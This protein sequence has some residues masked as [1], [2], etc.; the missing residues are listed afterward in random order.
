M[1]TVRILLI[2]AAVG[3]LAG[4]GGVVGVSS[5][6][7]TTV[8]A[9]GSVPRASLPTADV[10]PAAA[11]APAA[12]PTAP[13]GTSAPAPNVEKQ[14]SSVISDLSAAEEMKSKLEEGQEAYSS[15]C[16]DALEKIDTAAH[17]VESRAVARAV[18]GLY[19]ALQNDCRA[20]VHQIAAHIRQ[21]DDV[22]ALKADISTLKTIIHE[23]S[24]LNGQGA[25]IDNALV[26]AAAYVA[27]TKERAE[28]LRTDA[29]RELDKLSPKT[30][31]HSM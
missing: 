15:A 6:T 20:R 18:S 30:P 8:S 19:V 21:V 25:T 5:T 28:R 12:S 22:L 1:N 17:A 16:T 11:T 4:C 27:D 9:V 14:L 29:M 7:N 24:D 23:A 2:L 31:F 26:K 10:R 3:V 13:S